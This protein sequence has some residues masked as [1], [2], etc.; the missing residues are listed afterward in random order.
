M[1]HSRTFV[2]AAVLVAGCLLAGC[3]SDKAPEAQDSNGTTQAK[4]QAPA[5]PESA[6]PDKAGKGSK[7]TKAAAAAERQ[8]KPTSPTG[9]A[10]KADAKAGKGGGSSAGGNEG[11]RLEIVRKSGEKPDLKAPD[12]GTSGTP[13]AK[14]PGPMRLGDSRGLNTPQAEPAG[15]SSGRGTARPSAGTSDSPVRTTVIGDSRANAKPTR[16]HDPTKPWPA[17][18][19]PP[20][21]FACKNCGHE[22]EM[23]Y[24]EGQEKLKEA[25]KNAEPGSVPT[26]KCPKCSKMTVTTAKHCPKCAATMHAMSL[27]DLRDKKTAFFDECPN[28]GHSP[29]RARL[30]EQLRK[31]KA[32][33]K[34]PDKLIRG[35]VAEAIEWAKQHG[36]WP[37]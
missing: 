36:E 28:C 16:R 18:E 15:G 35:R 22:F 6:A 8:P 26:L 24:K 7:G 11:E 23:D 1:N 21:L 37:E 29:M 30:L 33:G 3:K 17:I 9:P 10:I 12:A 4:T 5:D 19:L 34:L 31:R 2:L 13:A 27:K 20:M 14:P 32:A 25:G